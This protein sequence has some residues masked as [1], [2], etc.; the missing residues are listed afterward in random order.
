MKAYER[1]LK[2]N[3][4]EEKVQRETGT[5]QRACGDGEEVDF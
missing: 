2:G 3:D 4:S 1:R 5:E